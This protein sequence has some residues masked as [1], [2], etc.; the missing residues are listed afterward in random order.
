MKKT[1]LSILDFLL[2]MISPLMIVGLFFITASRV[3][4]FAMDL[5]MDKPFLKNFIYSLPLFTPFLIYFILSY[6][7]LKS[8]GG[9]KR[10]LELFSKKRSR[11]Y[12]FIKL[13]DK[14]LF[15][16]FMLLF[17]PIIFFFSVIAVGLLPLM[18]TVWRNADDYW[19]ISIVIGTG[20]ILYFPTYFFRY[21]IKK[22]LKSDSN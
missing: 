12:R 11:V 17:T 19:L 8:K 14:I 9:F 7:R 4:A 2:I 16:P 1:F 20:C 22:N 6:F 10:L 18:G 15:N 13:I 3:F 21:L 5:G